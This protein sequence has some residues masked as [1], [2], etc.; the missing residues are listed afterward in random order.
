MYGH[1]IASSWRS[2]AS[3]WSGGSVKKTRASRSSV[4]RYVPPAVTPM[5][6]QNRAAC[7]RK[8]IEAHSAERNGLRSDSGRLRCRVG[9]V[10]G[11]AGGAGGVSIY[12]V[13]GEGGDTGRTGGRADGRTG[14]R[15]DG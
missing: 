2:G 4:G 3:L 8:L 10:V 13:G 15:A 11:S 5:A 14:G 12:D 9:C 1:W 7:A 6:R